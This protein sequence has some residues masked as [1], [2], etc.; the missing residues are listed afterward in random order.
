MPEVGDASF[1]AG[2]FLGGRG[3]RHYLAGE[4]SLAAHAGISW[5]GGQRALLTGRAAS[6]K[7]GDIT[8]RTRA[9]GIRAV[10]EEPQ[11]PCSCI[12]E[13]TAIPDKTEPQVSHGE[14]VLGHPGLYLDWKMCW[15]RGS[16]SRA[17][18]QTAS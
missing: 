12:S 16:R 18:L 14:E 1:G 13:I 6:H 4:D 2:P 17:L 15:L 3:L 10:N 11:V 7:G 8:R 9:H 5:G